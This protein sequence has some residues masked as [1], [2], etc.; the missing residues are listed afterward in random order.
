MGAVSVA[1]AIIHFSSRHNKGA[2]HKYHVIAVLTGSIKFALPVALDCKT[3]YMLRQYG[4]LGRLYKLQ[5]SVAVA[6]LKYAPVD[7]SD[8]D[9]D[10]EPSQSGSG[11]DA[12]DSSDLDSADMDGR[13]EVGSDDE[14]GL[15]DDEFGTDGA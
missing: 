6:G 11:Q 12:E 2:G 5:C 15:M 8:D 14:L 13:L 1:I 9:D 7:D 10:E 4:F 3:L